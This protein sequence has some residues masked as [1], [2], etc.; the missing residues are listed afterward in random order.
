VDYLDILDIQTLSS[1]LPGHYLTILGFTWTKKKKPMAAA[2][3][4]LKGIEAEGAA[5]RAEPRPSLSPEQVEG[6]LRIWG[7]YQVVRA[8][9][10]QRGY[11]SGGMGQ[12]EGWGRRHMG[13]ACAASM[14]VER[15]L[16]K[17][18]GKL[19]LILRQKYQWGLSD[20][21][22]RRDERLRMGRYAYVSAKAR[23]VEVLMRVLR[24]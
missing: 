12:W 24:A 21:E 2:E 3:D 6:L 7:E 5:D 11:R 22:G 8:D 20:E 4:T 18:D 13:G 10:P 9:A 1:L 15:A 23:A 16:E 19:A 14:R 17:M